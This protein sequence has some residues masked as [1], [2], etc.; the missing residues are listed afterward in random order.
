MCQIIH[1]DHRSLQLCF[2]GIDGYKIL[3]CVPEDS[4]AA[5]YQQ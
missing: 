5:I 2:M 4:P 1:R 3:T